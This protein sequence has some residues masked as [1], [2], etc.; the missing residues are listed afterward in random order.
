MKISNLTKDECLKIALKYGS[1]N[2]FIKNDRKIYRLSSRKGWL[3]EICSHMVSPYKLNYWTKDLCKKLA[4]EFK[5]RREFQLKYRVAYNKSLKNGWLDE[6][7]SHMVTSG[8]K[9]KRCI[10]AIEFPDK[11]VYIGLTYNLEKRFSK[12][13][14]DPKS[15]VYRYIKISNLDPTLK[16]LTDYIDVDLASKEESIKLQ[17]YLN[18]GW[19]VINISK[20]GSV[21]GKFIKWSKEICHMEAKKYK[22]RN[23]FKV[24]S[25]QAYHAARRNGWIEEISSH[26]DPVHPSRLK[27][28]LGK[29]KSNSPI[30]D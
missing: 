3:D 5:T 29:I 27:K 23:H 26:M 8:H 30:G 14:S 24:N 16:Q 22:R 1:R 19:G 6:I 21:G 12:H 10:Y 7:C 2:E 11:K 9:Y 25:P 15:S 18:N 20:C 17:E 13:I 28:L 4:S